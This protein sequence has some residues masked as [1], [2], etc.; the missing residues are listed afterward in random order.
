[1]LMV[2]RQT[3]EYFSIW[4][5]GV[6]AAIAPRSPALL[7]LPRLTRVLTLASL[8]MV[9][10]TATV[11]RLRIETSG[12]DLLRMFLPNLVLGAATALF[13]YVILH[14]RANPATRFW[15]MYRSMAQILSRSSYTLYLVHPSLL[16]FL[17]AWLVGGKAWRPDLK[18]IALGAGV[19]LFVMAY[20]YLISRVTEYKTNDVRRLVMRL[21]KQ[22]RIA[23]Q[24]SG[25]PSVSA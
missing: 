5:L 2:G 4:L 8:A 23:P 22:T 19:C 20:A 21:L 12:N 3:S 7:R 24:L 16:V 14:R 18:H 15:T 9:A 11:A 6:V 1:M 25:Q 17:S 10:I 13:I